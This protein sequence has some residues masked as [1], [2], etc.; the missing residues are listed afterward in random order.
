LRNNA[1][2][3][4]I[5]DPFTR[6]ESSDMLMKYCLIRSAAQQHSEHEH[7]PIA[8]LVDGRPII[9]HV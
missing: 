4:T 1:D 9:G 3:V 5:F 2:A 8:V 6:L 7:V